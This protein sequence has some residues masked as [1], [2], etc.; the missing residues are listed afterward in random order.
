MFY[1]HNIECFVDPRSTMISM[2][3]AYMR[4]PGSWEI[5]PISDIDVANGPNKNLLGIIYNSN[6]HSFLEYPNI[7]ASSLF[8]CTEFRCMKLLMTVQNNRHVDL[9]FYNSMINR[10]GLSEFKYMFQW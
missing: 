9:W 5:L 8:A 2:D 6:T 10:H 1:L 7:I 3:N 4:L